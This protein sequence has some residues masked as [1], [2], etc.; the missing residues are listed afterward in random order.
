MPTLPYSTLE[1]EES[2]F[3]MELASYISEDDMDDEELVD[4]LLDD[5][6]MPFMRIRHQEIG[7]ERF[8]MARL[9]RQDFFS[10]AASRFFFLLLGL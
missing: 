5:S 1:L 7:P 8:S 4:W 3:F 10:P 6:V 2:E 9:Q